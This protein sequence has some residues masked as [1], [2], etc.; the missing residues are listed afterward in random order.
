MEITDYTFDSYFPELLTPIE[1]HIPCANTRRET[2]I[3]KQDSVPMKH[4]VLLSSTGSNIFLGSSAQYLHQEQAAPIPIVEQK[5]PKKEK[6]EKKEKGEKRKRND[7]Q[8]STEKSKKSNKKRTNYCFQIHKSCCPFE[9]R[10]RL[11]CR[12]YLQGKLRETC[13]LTK[14]A[15]GKYAYTFFDER[16]QKRERRYWP[17]QS[18]GTC[19]EVKCTCSSCGSDENSETVQE[20][21]TTPQQQEQ[22][23]PQQEQEEEEQ[24]E[25]EEQRDCQLAPI[26]IKQE[27]C[28]SSTQIEQLYLPVPLSS[29][30]SSFD[31]S[32]SS[33]NISSAF[34]NN[35]VVF[36]EDVIFD[37]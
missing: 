17:S 37:F 27:V 8:K 31:C 35:T 2:T 10:E 21:C 32:V 4:N 25:E 16:K 23:E 19:T 13:A 3:F 22:Q 14:G 30:S 20:V 28:E 18:C 9:K 24:E 15:R 33:D 5:S 1:I 6:K 34:A 29:T 11:F 26:H 12:V 7:E 36:L